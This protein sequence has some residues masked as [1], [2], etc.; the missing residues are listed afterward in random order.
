MN[1]V[2]PVDSTVQRYLFN[3]RS[4]TLEKVEKKANSQEENQLKM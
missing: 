2:V 3:L 4:L 1:C